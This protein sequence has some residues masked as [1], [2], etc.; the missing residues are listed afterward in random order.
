MRF[1]T[2]S[3]LFSAEIGAAGCLWCQASESTD[4]VRT[5]AFLHSGAEQLN[6]QWRLQQQR[7][8]QRLVQGLPHDLYAL[9]RHQRPAPA[10]S[11]APALRQ[12]LHPEP[13]AALRPQPREL[14]SSNILPLS[15]LEL[16]LT[17]DECT[18]DWLTESAG[19]ASSD[20]AHLAAWA[21]GAASRGPS[22]AAQGAVASGAAAERGSAAWREMHSGGLPQQQRRRGGAG[23]AA[24]LRRHNNKVLAE[25]GILDG[26][27]PWAIVSPFD[28]ATAVKVRADTKPLSLPC[29]ETL[30][31]IFR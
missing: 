11:P 9:L 18:P 19:L 24:A 3:C 23:Q 4:G 21:L 12:R 13:Q 25:A 20:G 14:E 17:P 22:A 26:A 6:A 27:A 10:L 28:A 15:A 2:A 7:D 8:A 16:Q 31:L 29:L 1:R 30:I 5:A